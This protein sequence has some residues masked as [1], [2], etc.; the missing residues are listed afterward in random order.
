MFSLIESL[1]VC[2]FVFAGSRSIFFGL[3]VKRAIVILISCE[4]RNFSPL[5]TTGL[6]IK[7]CFKNQ[8]T[9]RVMPYCSYRL[10]STGNSNYFNFWGLLFLGQFCCRTFTEW[11]TSIC[12]HRSSFTRYFQIRLFSLILCF[13]FHERGNE[14]IALSSH[15]TTRKNSTTKQHK[16]PRVFNYD[17]MVFILNDATKIRCSRRIS[18]AF[19]RTGC[20]CEGAHLPST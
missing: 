17:L 11:I 18:L 20:S 7:L 12:C 15:L 9:V 6:K 13:I 14:F 5:F 19:S 8:I 10:S 16:N 2:Q 1:E 3:T 4:K